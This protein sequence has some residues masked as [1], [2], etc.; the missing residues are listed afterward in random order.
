MVANQLGNQTIICDVGGFSENNK[1]LR[2][3]R[4]LFEQLVRSRVDG[5][6]FVSCVAK[7]YAG[8]YLG[9][10]VSMVNQ[11]KPTPLVSLERD[12]SAYGITSV[13]YDCEENTKMAIKHLIDIGCKKITYIAGPDTLQVAID[14]TNGVLECARKYKIDFNPLIQM[15]KGDYTH[16]S[17]YLS[18]K[19]LLKDVPDLDGV[20]IA[21]D[22]MAVGALKLLKEYGKKVPHDIKVI[23]Y[24]DVFFSSMIEPS[25]S[26]I[27][28]SKRHAGI[29][30]AKILFSLI[31]GDDSYKLKSIKKD[32]RL[33]IR[34]ST[35]SDAP[36]DW[37]LADW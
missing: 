11:Y 12:F 5:I 26:T 37:I 27:H 6:L 10:I 9:E 28:I 25:L 13:Y 4:K 7:D 23:G 21:N 14:R 30:A 36:E 2:T 15:S 34:K 1:A 17:G 22:Q 20:F 3:E 8:E 35:V 19:Q 16:Q 29:D 24:D 31:E 33:V 32:G 18:M